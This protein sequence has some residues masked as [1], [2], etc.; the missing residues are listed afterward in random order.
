MKLS[1]LLRKYD[2][3][4]TFIITEKT[5]AFDKNQPIITAFD[6]DSTHSVHSTR[7]LIAH[8]EWNK[9]PESERENDL[10]KD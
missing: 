3:L 1:D 7:W 4:A 8:T 5:E 9:L 10:W 6:W 2:L